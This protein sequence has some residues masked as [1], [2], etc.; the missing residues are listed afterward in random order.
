MNRVNI[1]EGTEHR[2]RIFLYRSTRKN[3][4][5]GDIHSETYRWISPFCY[6]FSKQDAKSTL[7]FESV[8][9]SGRHHLL[10]TSLHN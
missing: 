4:R 7:F 5:S 8:V 3:T 9:V 2:A 10:R 6:L 1:L